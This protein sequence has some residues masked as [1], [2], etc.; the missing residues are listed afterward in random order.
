M[1]QIKKPLSPPTVG[2]MF[3]R[4]DGGKLE[5]LSVTR[6][7]GTEIQPAAPAAPKLELDGHAPDGK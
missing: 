2:G 4:V 6:Q 1:K 7:P 3:R 5:P